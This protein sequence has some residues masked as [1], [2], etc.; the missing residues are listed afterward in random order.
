MLVGLELSPAILYVD[1]ELANLELFR[2]VFDE[3]F[4][5]LTAASGAEAIEILATHEVGVLITDQRMPKMTGIELLQRAEAGFESVTRMLLTA[6]SDRELLLSAINQGHAHDYVL[7]PWNAEDLS[8][9]LKKGLQAHLHRKRLEH[10]EAERDLLARELV[11][12]AP[13]DAVIGLDGGLKSID[14]MLARISPTDSTVMI[15]GETGTGKELVAREI[16]RRS[17]R[18][19]GPFVRTNCAALHEGLLE[20][21]LFGHESGAFTGA[22]T[23]R[24]GRFEQAHRGTIF[25]D[26]IGDI[27]A[28]VQVKLLRVLQERELERVGGTRAIKVD[29]RVLSATNRNLEDAVRAGRFREDLFYRLNVVPI[30]LPPLRARPED[31][32]PLALH[33]V[34]RHAKELGKRL[35]ITREALDMLRRYDWPGN[36]RELK[37]LIERAAVLADDGASLGPEDFIFDFWGASES[38]SVFEKIAGDEANAIKE[39]LKAAKG[40]KTKAARLLGMPRTTLNDRIKKLGIR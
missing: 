10:A 23:M 35:S 21:E 2:R 31:V 12:R 17:A 5:V 3:D 40:S 13:F 25:L 7:K 19:S 30:H 11:E 14:E 29:I 16:H 24:I 8:V 6:Y 37:N 33:L 4:R 18:A 15:R 27:S 20:S 38:E 39:A 22:Q 26:E 9:R 32:E 28:A 1:D 34:E 36:V